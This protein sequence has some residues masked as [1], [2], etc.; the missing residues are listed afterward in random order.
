MYDH[1]PY[2]GS[3]PHFHDLSEVWQGVALWTTLSVR[4][5][6]LVRRIELYRLKSYLLMRT[7]DSPIR[8]VAESFVDD[9]IDYWKDEQRC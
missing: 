8:N 7:A 2:P 1:Y 6:V 9:D 3:Y 4:W 5:D